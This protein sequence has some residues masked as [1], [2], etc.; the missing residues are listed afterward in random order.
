MLDYRLEYFSYFGTTASTLSDVERNA[1]FVSAFPTVLEGNSLPDITTGEKQPVG[2][3]PVKGQGTVAVQL[4]PSTYFAITLSPSPQL[5]DGGTT[6][7]LELTDSTAKF[8]SV[9]TTIDTKNPIRKEEI[10]A[11]FPKGIDAAKLIPGVDDLFWLSVDK[12]NGVIRYGKTFRTA[13]VTYLMATVDVG[14][15][16]TKPGPFIWIKQLEYVSISSQQTNYDIR[17]DIGKVSIGRLPIVDDLPPVI[18]ESI[19]LSLEDLALNTT[20]S[21][22]N[23]DP[24]CQRLYGNIAGPNIQLDDKNFPDF[25][26]ALE[27]SIRTPGCICYEN[28][29]S[30]VGEFGNDPSMT[31]LRITL[32]LD[33]G[34][35]P[36]V[37]FVVEIWPSKHKSPIHDHGEAYAVI[38]VLHGKI[39]AS[40]FNKLDKVNVKLEP[41]IML[42][43]GNITW[44]GPD[45]YQVHQLHNDFDRVCVTI[46]CYQYAKKDMSHD[47]YFEYLEEETN[48]KKP[49]KPDSDW[50]FI[51]FKKL[52]KEEWERHLKE[53]E[54]K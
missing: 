27:Y 3:L 46:Q 19:A 35:S 18:T 21:I 11:T 45:N 15:I 2:T 54:W 30:K 40:Y 22:A 37:P 52:V 7:Q 42:E 50:D 47:E 5:K 29:K 25:S 41:D 39:N 17:P 13:A 36:G 23:L 8:F 10:T 38:K 44:I 4:K 43:K 28:L 14:D 31:Y 49:F 24:A 1:G 6:L 9:T 16:V 34:N 33:E 20:T 26:Q 48:D 32:G 51:S 53:L 12:E